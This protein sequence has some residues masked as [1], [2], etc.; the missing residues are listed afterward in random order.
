[1]NNDIKGIHAYV[2]NNKRHPVGVLAAV[3]SKVNPHEVVIGWSKCNLSA[4][5]R[6]NRAEGV[7]IAYARSET[8][9]TQDIPITMEVE[10]NAFFDRATKYFKDRAVIV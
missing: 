1:M 6:F 8:Q 9:S 4:G 2:Y 7:R 10:Y 5:D 3:P